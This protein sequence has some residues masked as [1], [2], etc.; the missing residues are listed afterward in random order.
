MLPLLL[1]YTITDLSGKSW[2]SSHKFKNSQIF[3]Y[4]II[5]FLSLRSS[6]NKNI[7]SL[8]GVIK[9]LL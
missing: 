9:S 8:V 3:V 4:L 5:D 1:D 7:E 6:S 2:I